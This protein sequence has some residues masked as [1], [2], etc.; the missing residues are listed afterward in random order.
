MAKV[1]RT[2][3]RCR[4]LGQAV[5]AGRWRPHSEAPHP[6]CLAG[7]LRNR[8]T[9]PAAARA[10]AAKRAQLAARPARAEPGVLRPRARGKSRR[11]QLLTEAGGG[12]LPGASGSPRCTEAAAAKSPRC[13]R[14]PVC[15]P[16]RREAARPGKPRPREPQREGPFVHLDT[17]ACGQGG[18][19]CPWP[20]P[21]SSLGQPPLSFQVFERVVWGE[22]AGWRRC[23]TWNRSLN[24]F[25]A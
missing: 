2:L 6:E 10:P 21:Q 17:L 11:P 16:G 4:H 1:P 12:R 23:Q 14:R 25:E 9:L 15:G 18:C 20:P 22:S 3:Q 5:S 19:R 24:F 8:S 7:L 13:C